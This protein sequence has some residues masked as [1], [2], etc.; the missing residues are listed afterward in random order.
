MYICCSHTHSHTHTHTHTHTHMQRPTAKEL[1][2]HRF[3]KNAKKN[4]C[5]TDLIERYRRWKAEGRDVDSGSE[6]S[7]EEAGSVGCLVAT[8]RFCSNASDFPA[9]ISW[10]LLAGLCGGGYWGFKLV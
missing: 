5:L 4:S 2:K 9:A 8:L 6:Q 3:I 1:L 7:D 10:L